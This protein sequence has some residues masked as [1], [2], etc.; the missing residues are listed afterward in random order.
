MRTLKKH[1]F[2]YYFNDELS[3]CKTCGKLIKFSKWFQLFCSNR[4]IGLNKDIQ[5]AKNNTFLKNYGVKNSNELKGIKEK[6][7]KTC[8]EKWTER[9]RIKIKK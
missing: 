2:S 1:H 9:F 6:V 4:C 3:K 5:T 7:Q 8:L